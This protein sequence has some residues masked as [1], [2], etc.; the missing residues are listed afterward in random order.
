MHAEVRS[1]FLNRDGVRLRVVVEGNPE[2]P[3]VVL[4]HGYPDDLQVWDGVVAHLQ[5]D[6]RVVR[7][8][9][10]G[11]G[12]SSAP[13]GRDAYTLEELS[14]DLMAVLKNVSPDAPVHLV[15]HDWG[16]IQLWESV[17]NEALRDR[18][19]SFTSASGPSVDFI[20]T[21]GRENVQS[22]E[23]RRILASVNQAR[24][25]WYVWMFQLPFL[26][27]LSWSA[28]SAPRI[29]EQ[30]ARADRLPL[31]VFHDPNRAKNGRQGVMLYRANMRQR[32]ANP[33]PA[34]STV[35]TQVLVATYDPYVTPGIAHSCEAW[36][37]DLRFE[38]VAG[39]HWFYLADPS[40]LADPVRRFVREIE[41][42]GLTS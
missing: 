12:A 16:S 14:L 5:D 20:A 7:Y 27:E 34:H 18:F 29:E 6:F 4:V 19:A 35:P 3:T 38:S 23:W 2:G 42:R 8:D 24:R 21:Q 10:R 33:K 1:F 11:A 17:T 31:A 30:M 26:P 39:A 32:M 36:M 41:A 15:G 22:G 13:V 25:S 37:S 28:R 40:L 9:V